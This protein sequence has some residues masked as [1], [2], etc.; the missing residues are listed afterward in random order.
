MD[1]EDD[2]LDFAVP[3]VL[4]ALPLLLPVPEDEPPDDAPPDDLAVPDDE[5]P[6]LE[7]EEASVVA[8]A[9]EAVVVAAADVMTSD[10]LGAAALV[11]PRVTAGAMVVVNIL[12]Q[13]PLCML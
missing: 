6:V 8:A 7:S 11:L 3:V 4:E 10:G 13:F 9:E 5:V 12:I 1:V 2:P